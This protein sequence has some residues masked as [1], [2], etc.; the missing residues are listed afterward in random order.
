MN[1]VDSNALPSVRATNGARLPL[2][3]PPLVFAIDNG[4]GTTE[5]LWG[6][7][8]LHGRAVVYC[9]CRY[10]FDD[11][12]WRD[13]RSETLRLNGRNKTTDRP[14]YL[15]IPTGG[16][17]WLRWPTACVPDGSVP[18]YTVYPAPTDWRVRLS[19]QERGRR[20]RKFPEWRE[21]HVLIQSA[22]HNG[23]VAVSILRL[24]PSA[25]VRGIDGRPVLP[26]GILPLGR[27]SS[28]HV[29]AEMDAWERAQK[30]ESLISNLLF[31]R[32]DWDEDDMEAL[33]VEMGSDEVGFA[34]LI[35][36]PVVL[37]S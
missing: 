30:A 26:I 12:M 13:R 34:T 36:V 27:N 33:I 37:T 4:D 35:R 32:D 29:V 15:Y 11:R 28:L 9:G 6:V 7:D 22:G 24:H 17:L 21:P 20:A 3:A 25:T 1:E 16:C 5:N 10:P 18:C 31:G 19:E 2:R 8:I 23:V 14:G